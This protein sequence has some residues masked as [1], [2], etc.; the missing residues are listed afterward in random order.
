MV[1]TK[2]KLFIGLMV[3]ITLLSTP[4]SVEAQENVLYSTI[5][6]AKEMRDAGDYEQAAEVLKKLDNQNPGNIWVQRLYAET[7]IWL[8]DYEEATLVYEKAIKMHP[9]DMDVKYEFATFLFNLGE[10]ERAQELLLIYTQKNT[11]VA[12][13]EKLLGT[14]YYYLGDFLP[15]VEHLEKSL[16]LNPNDKNTLQLLDEVSRITKPW[17]GVGFAYRNDSQNITQLFPA[18]EG[19]LYKS[20]WFS[21]SFYLNAQNFSV[22]STDNNQINFGVR[23]SF[24]FSKIGLSA[25]FGVGVNYAS[26]IDSVYLLWDLALQQSLSDNL[27][28]SAKAERSAY[29][30][31][32]SSV[33]KPINSDKYNL[34]VEWK[35]QKS[36]WV[37][38]GYL[39]EVFPDANN[40][41]TAYI[42]AL[43]PSMSFS[44]FELRLGYS[45]S[46]ANSKESRYVTV[47][48]KQDIIN[49]FSEDEAIEGVYNPYY[50]PNKEFTNSVLGNLLLKPN[51]NLDIRLHA[52]VGI[53]SR[54][55]N[56]YFYL[57][58]NN[59]GQTIIKQD[60]FQESYTPMDLGIKINYGLSNALDL[61]ISYKYFQ[62][63]YFNSNNIQL[64][65][66]LRFN[67]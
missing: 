43:S 7:L 33:K 8:K 60:F 21:P 55:M 18:I 5:D 48:S 63:F 17:I 50:T 28:I 22:D 66:K 30:Y 64:G 41:Q 23:N 15:A 11:R 58:T 53:Y 67:K 2:V 16:E 31:T 39:A 35:K 1:T 36:L 44:I 62:S 38:I 12:K 14:T 65:L 34:F 59:A 13:A 26:S 27:I 19:G 49:D 25:K 40:I 32:I 20:S 3:F 47:K 10:Y 56:P 42:W 57:D 45:F 54:T 4:L 24:L 61:V 6:R 9:D 37:N 52:T 46:Y 51:S 29:T